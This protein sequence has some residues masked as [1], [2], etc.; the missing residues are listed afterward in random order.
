MALSLMNIHV[1]V[2][3]SA[4]RFFNVLASDLA[5]TDGT[6]IPA[7]SFLDDTGTAATA[8]PVVTNGYYNLYINGVLQ[9]GASYTITST[10]LTFNDVTGTIVAGTPLVVK[11]VE[12]NTLT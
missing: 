5:V 9:E 1:N 12:I 8:F 6:T 10:E 4:E 3:T 7:S 2:S 11:A